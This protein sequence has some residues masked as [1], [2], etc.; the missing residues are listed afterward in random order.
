M[1]RG[2]FVKLGLGFVAREIRNAAEGK[3]GPAAQKVY[4]SLEGSKTGIGFLLAVLCAV[5]VGLGNTGAE[6][7]AAGTIGGFLMSVGL[8]D[9][10]WRSAPPAWKQT[11][12][13]FFASEHAHDI[14]AVFGI[15]TAW[16]SSCD[17]GTTETLA[18]V[19]LTCSSAALVLFV[20]SVALVQLGLMAEAKLSI[21]PRSGA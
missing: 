12:L 19:G 7:Y 21:P 9:K 13:Y 8:I 10:S 18:R 5:L 20:V 11:Q 6:A 1:I 4:T 3:H 15:A 2:V 14:A 17:P 16:V